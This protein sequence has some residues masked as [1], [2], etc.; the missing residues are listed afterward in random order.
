MFNFFWCVKLLEV[1]CFFS[2]NE[3]FV[4]VRIEEVVC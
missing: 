1:V 4:L 2:F 3:C